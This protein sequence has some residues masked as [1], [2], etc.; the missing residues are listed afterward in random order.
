MKIQTLI[1]VI[2]TLFI[3]LYLLFVGIFI[4]LR[5]SGAVQLS[6]WVVLMPLYLPGGVVALGTVIFF[7]FLKERDK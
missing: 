3:I 2:H 4:G 5:I 7:L 1:E 6:W